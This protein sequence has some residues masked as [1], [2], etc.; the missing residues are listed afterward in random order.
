MLA[1]L[2]NNLGFEIEDLKGGTI[3]ALL[4]DSDLPVEVREV[5]H[6]RS[7]AAA[8]SPAKYKVL[9]RGVSREVGSDG[10]ED[11]GGVVVR[12]GVGHECDTKHGKLAEGKRAAR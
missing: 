2:Q 9:Q 1:Y 6:I 5:L 12:G 8:T 10:G 11:A 3:D 4:K 7:Q